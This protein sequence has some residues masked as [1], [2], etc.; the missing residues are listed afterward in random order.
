MEDR[1]VLSTADGTKRGIVITEGEEIPKGGQVIYPIICE[2]DV[3]GS[4]AILAMEE[5]ESVDV[6]E[7]K[8]AGVAA[9]FLG[10]QMEG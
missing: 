9:S 5:Q 10:R 3:I 7:Q 6:T 1:E 8:L 2:G 4:V